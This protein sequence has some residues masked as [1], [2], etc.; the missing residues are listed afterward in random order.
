MLMIYSS[1]VRTHVLKLSTKPPTNRLSL[2]LPEP[3]P[4]RI[5]HCSHFLRK[6]TKLLH[7]LR[8]PL[9]LEMLQNPITESSDRKGVKLPHVYEPE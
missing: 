1:C 6:I 7:K 4:F 5:E 2:F 8:S 3:P 9:E